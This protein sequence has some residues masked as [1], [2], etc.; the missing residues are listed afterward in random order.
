MR[1]WWSCCRSLQAHDPLA[2][3]GTGFDADALAALAEA[4]GLGNGTG[5]AR[6]WA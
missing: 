2:L 5:E 3:L 1:C 4:Q 6:G